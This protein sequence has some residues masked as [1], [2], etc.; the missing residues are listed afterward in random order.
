[1]Q[2]NLFVCEEC[3]KNWK[4]LKKIL[5]FFFHKTNSHYHIWIVPISGVPQNTLEDW[6]PLP[7]YKVGLTIPILDLTVF[8]LSVY[9]IAFNYSDFSFDRLLTSIYWSSL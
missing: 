9:I 2:K 1:M 5:K 4:E 3:P 6:V 8:D 7:P